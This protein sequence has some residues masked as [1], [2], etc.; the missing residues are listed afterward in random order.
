[1]NARMATRIAILAFL[2]LGVPRALANGRYPTASDLAF[3]PGGATGASGHPQ[4]MA[5]RTTFGL[6]STI[7]G[8]AT[9]AVTCEPAI[10]FTNEW[11]AP[12][13]F[14]AGGS[15]LMGIPAGLV[16][17]APRFC[18]FERPPT[19][20]EEAVVDL[21]VDARGRRLVA[22]AVANG[23]AVSDDDGITWRRGWANDKFLVATIEVAPGHPERIY[24]SGY[25]DSTAVL[26]RSD[27]GAATFTEVTR[28]LLG[29]LAGYIAAVD[30]GNPDV[31]YLRIDLRAGGTVLARSDDGGHTLHELTRT[32]S[33]MTGTA[34]SDDGRTL[35][36]G[37]RGLG[38]GDGLFRSSDGGTT[39][40]R[41]GAELTPLCL[42]HRAGVLY[43]C[44]DDRR[45]GFSLG[46]SRDGGEHFA[47]L[48][49]WR[50]LMGPEVC[51]ADS[52]GRRL[53]EADWPALRATL[54]PP[55]AGAPGTGAD[56]AID[57]SVAD[58]ST[59]TGTGVDSGAE[60]RKSGDGCSCSATD[61]ADGGGVLLLVAWAAL[62]GGKICNKRRRLSPI[63]SEGEPHEAARIL[64]S[65][66]DAPRGCLLGRR[67]PPGPGPGRHARRR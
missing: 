41:L 21:T 9:W 3:V 62:L 51:P 63:N 48:L 5:L 52:P 25:L 20:P 14:S 26:M 12:L 24:A 53:C 65:R 2:F 36:V 55:D 35:W 60:P 38:A 16:L 49:S 54:S 7:D 27:D 64:H 40:Q 66:P 31:L 50:D 1:M 59:D 45:D 46:F 28:D 33:P 47:P 58:G 44:A 42:R 8:G 61:G 13:A 43:I 67:D 18:D 56:A 6:V 37:S 11:D 10:G 39:W 22:A 23:I 32:T 57:A 17:A 19:A 30:A 15:A 34:V 4:V 29:G